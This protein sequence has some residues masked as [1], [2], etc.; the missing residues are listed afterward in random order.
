M[1][2]L[3]KIYRDVSKKIIKQKL[4]RANW[5]QKLVL[6]GIIDEDSKL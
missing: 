3:E 4:K 6:K 2:D 1:N 5:L